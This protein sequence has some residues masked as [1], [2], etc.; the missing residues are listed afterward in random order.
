M[1]RSMPWSTSTASSPV[2][3]VLVTPVSSMRGIARVASACASM[4]MASSSFTCVLVCV[5][6]CVLICALHAW[7]H[8]P[9]AGGW[10]R[11]RRRRDRALPDHDLLAGIQTRQDL[12]GDAAHQTD[13]HVAILDRPV[14][15]HDADDGGAVGQTGAGVGRRRGVTGAGAAAAL[16]GRR[17]RRT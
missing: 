5:L 3:Y 13:A 16:A 10:L 9:V 2:R 14:G 1:A 12:R 4:V 17:A 15:L 8:R 6:I 11:R 7:H